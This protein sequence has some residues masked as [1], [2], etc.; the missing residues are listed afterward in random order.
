VAKYEAAG[1]I[2]DDD[3]KDWNVD[4][5]FKSLKEGTDQAN[6]MRRERGIPELEVLGWIEKPHY[7]AAARRLVWA[8]AV[9]SKGQGD[10][11]ARQSVNYNTLCAGARRLHQPEPDRRAPTHR[12]GQALCAHAARLDQAG[13]ASAVEPHF[14]Q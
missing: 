2:K 7:D 1:Y 13:T 14:G 3:A 9:R 5:L 4:D 10:E 11:E 6:Q 8:M 12:A